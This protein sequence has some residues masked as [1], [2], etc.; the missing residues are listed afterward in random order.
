MSRELSNLLFLI[1]LVALGLFL[2]LM[3]ALSIY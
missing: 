2:G 3:C 1:Y